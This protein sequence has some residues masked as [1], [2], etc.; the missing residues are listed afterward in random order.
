MYYRSVMS[1]TTV[2]LQRCSSHVT[3]TAC[4]RL[5]PSYSSAHNNLATLLMTSQQRDAALRHL[6]MA[7]KHNPQHANSHYNLA[8]LAWY[9]GVDG[10]QRTHKHPQCPH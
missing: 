7:T 4:C 3:L 5:W 8:A 1:D 10:V 2:A 6:E 9:V